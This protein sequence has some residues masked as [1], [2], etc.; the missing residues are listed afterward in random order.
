[1]VAICRSVAEDL[2]TFE[3]DR[4]ARLHTVYIGCEL[5][6]FLEVGQG[7]GALKRELGLDPSAFLAVCPARICHVKAQDLLIEALGIAGDGLDEKSFKLAFVGDGE[8]RDAAVARALPLGVGD[9]IAFPGYR[10][11]MLPVYADA[12]LVILPSRHEGTPIALMEATAAGRPFL[13][14]AVGGVSDM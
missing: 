5:A 13:A 3:I 9:R 6:Q 8:N 12:D 10:K 7:T 1:M 4:Y 11:D 14:T 2:R